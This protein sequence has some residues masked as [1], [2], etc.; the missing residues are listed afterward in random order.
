MD[1]PTGNSTP[2]ADESAS[3][4]VHARKQAPRPEGKMIRRY[5]DKMI[6]RYEDK[7]ESK[8]NT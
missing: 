3:G 8:G 5:E 4:A 6:R 1:R 7:A 2:D